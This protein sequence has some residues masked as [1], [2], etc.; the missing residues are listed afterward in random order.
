M[1]KGE[2]EAIVAAQLRTPEGERAFRAVFELAA[3]KTADRFPPGSFGEALG[4][5]LA[6]LPLRGGSDG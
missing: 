6:G 5:M 3:A 4:R 1:T 2:R